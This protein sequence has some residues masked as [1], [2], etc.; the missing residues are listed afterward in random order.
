MIGC[1]SLRVHCNELAVNNMSAILDIDLI[2]FERGDSSARRAI[3]D[4]TMRSLSS[5]FV[6]VCHDLS[7]SLLDETYG[8][9]AEFFALPQERKDHYTVPGSSGNFGYTGLLVETAAISDI[10]D[11]KEMLNWSAPVPEGHPL[12]R[13]FPDR[14]G[15]PV[16]P[17]DDIPGISAVLIEFHHVTLELQRWV[18]RILAAGL[19]VHESYFDLMLENGGALNRALHYPSM[20]QAPSQNHV[21]SGE[22]GDINLMTALPRAIGAGLQVKTTDGWVDVMPPDQ[23]AI[24]NT[25]I[26]LDHLTNGLIPTGIHRVAAK[27]PGERYSV[28]QFCHPTPWTM[29]APIPTCVTPENPLRYPTI[30]VG[31]LLDQVIWEI[32]M[33]ESGRRLND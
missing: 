8:K 23:H 10:P 29:L 2:A 3:V 1:G 30:M 7:Q 32:N 20:D 12:R 33:V 13:R 28:I 31:D 21:W 25:G 22:H 11:W 5:G 9:L 18:L 14:Y 26:M 6:Y 16:F 27:G 24:I 4:G 17:D 15:D 19:G